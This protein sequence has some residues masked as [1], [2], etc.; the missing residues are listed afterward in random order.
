[1]EQVLTQ[2]RIVITRRRKTDIALATRYCS[3]CGKT[4]P[5]GPLE[6]LVHFSGLYLGWRKHT[7]AHCNFT[8][9]RLEIVHDP[10]QV[11]Y[12]THVIC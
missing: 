2:R 4:M 3:E 12:Q 10:D 6:V 9:S 5:G 11:Q 1:M 8:E 7:C